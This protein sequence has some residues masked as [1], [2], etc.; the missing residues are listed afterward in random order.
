MN[1]TLSDG[2][3]VVCARFADKYPLVPPPSLYFAYG[4]A[5]QMQR[6]LCDD[7]NAEGSDDE[8]TPSDDSQAG[9]DVLDDTDAV[10][11]DLSFQQSLPG[12]LLKDVDPTSCAFIVSSD[13]LTKTSSEITWHRV[14]ANSILCYTRGS[15]PRLHK[16]NVGGAKKPEDYAFFLVDF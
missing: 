13:P 3:T 14:A 2:E 16:L 4:D 10:E 11:K 8:D 12:K 5:V 1:F 7:E 6:E 9:I 15:I